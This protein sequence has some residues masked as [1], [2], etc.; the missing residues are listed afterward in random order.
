MGEPDDVYDQLLATAQH[1][2]LV[3]VTGNAIHLLLVAEQQQQRHMHTP[4]PLTQLCGLMRL[5]RFSG[6]LQAAQRAVDQQRLQQAAVLPFG[7]QRTAAM[8]ELSEG[9]TTVSAFAKRV[10]AEFGAGRVHAALAAVGAAGPTGAGAGSQYQQRTAMLPPAYARPLSQGHHSSTPP[11]YVAPPPYGSTPPSYASSPPSYANSPPMQPAAQPLFQQQPQQA[12]QEQS[13]ASTSNSPPQSPMLALRDLA[14]TPAG[15]QP[16]LSL[17][18]A[19][20]MPDA[21]QQQQQQQQAPAARASKW[22]ASRAAQEQRMRITNPPAL[23]SSSPAPAPAASADSD[24][25]VLKW[26]GTSTGS[27][28]QQQQHDAT[29]PR[30]SSSSN[31]WS[32][33]RHLPP[34]ATTTSQGSQRPTATT[35]GSPPPAGALSNNNDH[36]GGSSAVPIAFAYWDIDNVAVPSHATWADALNGIEDA[37]AGAPDAMRFFTEVFVTKKSVV[38]PTV[39]KGFLATARVKLVSCEGDKEGADRRIRLSLQ[40]ELDKRAAGVGPSAEQ[41]VDVLV[42]S[43]QNL[44]HE[45]V[46][47]VRGRGG[48]RAVVLHAAPRGSAHERALQQLAAGSFV[49]T[50]RGFRCEVVSLLDGPGVWQK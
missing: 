21:P 44:A 27:Q 30:S 3:E 45:F 22:A 13:W 11:A 42:S 35:R 50:A 48:R 4:P 7:Q 15:Q 17:Q 33:E 34:G 41:C 43:D 36:S 5:Y 31:A 28:P 25:R 10:D 32:I 46:D 29:A 26:F 38:A 16:F 49:N 18:K 6:I 9:L 20:A 37:V 24:D 39:L 19:T 14:D 47:L 8:R 23:P 2:S 12:P 1:D 40:S